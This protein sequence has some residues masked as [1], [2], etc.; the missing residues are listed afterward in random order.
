GMPSAAMTERQ[1][2]EGLIDRRLQ[3]QE[4]RKQGI[5]VSPGE[6]DAYLEDLKKSN[7]IES[8]E[9]FRKA[10]AIEGLTL[11]KLRRDV[12]EHL[13]FLRIV[14]KEV[15]SKVIV[16]EPEVRKAYEEEIDKF[17]EPTQVRL[18]YLL[19]PL[20]AEASRE[21]AEEAKKRAEAALLRLKQGQDFS[22]IVK[23]Y[24]LG[25]MAEAGGDI[26]Y[27]KRGELHPEV[28]RVAFSL[29]AGQ[30]SEVIPLPSGFVII[31]VEERRTPIQPYAQV[32]D[33]LRDKIYEKKV[34]QKYKEWAQDL[35]QKAFV[36]MK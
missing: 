14:G 19:I 3:L 30:H 4:A 35:R 9:A 12:E 6:V 7:Q 8:E 32:A 34:A 21:E 26:G 24:S 22:Q 28:E 31:K 11:E 27:V 36:E 2:L 5:S 23:E 17:V 33:Q 1:I 18:R 13:I 15:R 20:A 25:P 10:L 16:S 29:R